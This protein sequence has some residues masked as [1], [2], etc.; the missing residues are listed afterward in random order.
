MTVV[1]KAEAGWQ[2]HLHGEEPR[3]SKSEEHKDER[4]VERP[5]Q[6]WKCLRKAGFCV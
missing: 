4:E 2:A 1:W 5:H 6:G 3:E